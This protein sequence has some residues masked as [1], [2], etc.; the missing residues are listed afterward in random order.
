MATS[1][2]YSA[3]TFVT[4]ANPAPGRQI[5]Y[6]YS[7]RS[8]TQWDVAYATR[9]DGGLGQNVYV[10]GGSGPSGSVIVYVQNAASSTISGTLQVTSTQANPV[11]VTG[12]LAVSIPAPSGTTVVTASS[13][14]P[15]GITGTVG[16]V[17]T[18]SVS[19]VSQSTPLNVT[20]TVTV[21]N[22]VV[23]T[24][25]LGTHSSFAFSTSSITV[26]A[27]NTSRKAFSIYNDS[28]QTYLVRLGSGASL[29]V[30]TLSLFPQQYYENPVPCFTG[31]VTGRGFV[32]GSGTIHVEEM[33]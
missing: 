1:S 18:A 4:A 14:N 9:S 32:S 22:Q 27:P 8:G 2:N 7:I 3:D 31:I 16:V 33:T 12:S 11:W 30:W 20:G 26:L 5:V 17:G 29:T 21:A 13:A 25:S 28:D 6:E 10:A 24:S 15:V 19:F 23:A